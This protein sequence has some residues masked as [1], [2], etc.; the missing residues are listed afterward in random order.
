MRK[1]LKNQLLDLLESIHAMHQILLVEKEK[2]SLVSY[3]SQCQQAAILIGEN[4]E[5]YAPEEVEIVE[6]LE[7]YCDEAFF[8]S[9]K[10]GVMPA[11]TAR[12]EAY[13]EQIKNM[14][15][16]L[17]LTYHVVFMPY[18]A[19]MWDSLESIWRA[20]RED[21]R[22]ECVVMP[23][24][25]YERNMTSGR[26]EPRYDGESFPEEASVVH[27]TDYFLEST[28]PD[29]AYIH[30]PYDDDNLVTSIDPKYYSS[31]LKRYVDQLVY[32]PYFVTAGMFPPVYLPVYKNMDY[33]ITQAPFVKEYFSDWMCKDKLLP[34]GSPKFDRVIRVC[35]STVHMVPQWEGVLYGRKVFMLNTSLICLLN[36]GSYLLKKLRQVFEL[37]SKQ[38]KLA[39]IWRPH[40]LLEA[41]IKSMEQELIQEYEA[42]VSYFKNNNIGVLD[43]TPDIENTIALA[44]GY[45]G[46]EAT[47]VVNLF[48]VAGKPV[49]ILNNYITDEISED[50]ERRVWISDLLCAEGKAWVV[51]S[52]YNGLLW[53]D[54]EAKEFHF[55]GRTPNQS[56]W[57]RT[58]ATLGIQGETLFL[59]PNVAHDAITYDIDK[60]CFQ[61]I[62][63][64]QENELTWRW[65]IPYDDK[66]IYLPWLEG[67][68]VE[69][70][71]TTQSWN[72]FSA[73]VESLVESKTD[74]NLPLLTG[75]CVSENDLWIP[76]S[77]GNRVLQFHMDLGTYSIHSVGK[78]ENAYF[79]IVM[80]GANIWMT[81]M[82]SGDVIRW[83]RHTGKTETIHMPEGI[84][85]RKARNGIE[86]MHFAL[87]DM[88]EF[89]V[90]IPW[91]SNSIVKIE[92]KTGK[93]TIIGG[94]FLK[95]VNLPA[96]NYCP[97]IHASV[98][99][100]KKLDDNRLMI[101]R[102]RDG[103]V[104]VINVEDGTYKQHYP[105]LTRED[106]KR[107][108]EGEDG[109]EQR[110]RQHGFF[111]RESLIFPLK[112]FM[113]DVANGNLFSTRMRQLDAMKQI[114]ENLDGTC[115]EKVHRYMMD[116][117][118]KNYGLP[119]NGGNLYVKNSYKVKW[120][121][122]R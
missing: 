105:T 95:D 107:F 25:Y 93:A 23:L 17:P 44:D 53:G 87:V 114:A 81:E 77:Q 16:R 111:K 91:L 67:P 63:V 102:T 110:S 113:E 109:F 28:M 100:Y 10:E 55:A 98:V 118:E 58:A 88:G 48:Q 6:V 115:G 92:K 68:I 14:I 29:I 120:N 104:A 27:H 26:W 1:R 70:N 12:L 51:S 96:N 35:Q 61:P 69:Y 5:E 21:K 90:T 99:F 39:L 41:T 45:I 57:F 11:D 65:V 54:E 20:C 37:F 31:E 106:Y 40:P 8:V 49:F 52:L 66:M 103:A 76:T 85:C 2:D 108:M 3:L 119:W 62:T 7:Q 82:H 56:K 22:C 50:E 19:E 89:V 71:T 46:E 9:G 18:K 86:I 38:D 59:A 80:V 43:R 101:Q 75:Y 74:T 15:Q 34:L 116:V 32:V 60:N 13:V 112:T 36:D 94:A 117:A 72:T 47:S 78:N 121:G 84:L 73:P 30:N 24:P 64:K 42:L 4:I 79:G 33:M 122:K 83:N 97:E